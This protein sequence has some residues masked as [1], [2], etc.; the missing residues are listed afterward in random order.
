M[1][2]R[3]SQERPK[4]ASIVSSNNSMGTCLYEMIV[5]PSEILVYFFRCR[6][7]SSS[8]AKVWERVSGKKCGLR[9]FQNIQIAEVH[10][11][12]TLLKRPMFLN[13]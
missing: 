11:L 12:N 5:F 2:L 7:Y 13:Y 9:N 3:T 8:K 6:F 10:F 4:S 1:Y